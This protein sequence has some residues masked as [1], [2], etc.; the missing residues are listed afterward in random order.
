MLLNDRFKS[1]FIIYDRVK[2]LSNFFY[3]FRQQGKFVY[4]F[5]ITL[6]HNFLISLM[7]VQME[8]GEAFIATQKNLIEVQ[9][10]G[11]QKVIQ[12]AKIVITGN[13]IIIEKE[14]MMYT[15]NE[16]CSQAQSFYTYY[17]FVRNRLDVLSRN[18]FDEKVKNIITKHPYKCIRNILL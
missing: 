2:R 18:E 11:L 14:Y 12:G 7:K 9:Q 1:Y 13:L 5:E 4:S 16:I 10:E 6:L 15:E 8:L 17:Q 3:A